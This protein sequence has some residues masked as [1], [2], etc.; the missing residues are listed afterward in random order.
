MKANDHKR[1]E[2]LRFSPEVIAK[3][4]AVLRLWAIEDLFATCSH[5]G[6]DCYNPDLPK[7]QHRRKKLPA[8]L[9]WKRDLLGFRGT[10][11]QVIC[12]ACDEEEFQ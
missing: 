9:F 7:G 5:C 4:E 2:D 8:D 1:L 11:G 10:S 6:R 3:T 12:W